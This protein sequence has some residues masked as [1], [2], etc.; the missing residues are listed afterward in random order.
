M[1]YSSDQFKP[2]EA[3]LIFRLNSFIQVK[4]KPVD[5][6]MLIVLGVN[7]I[8]SN[9]TYVCDHFEKR[10]AR[11]ENP[12]GFY[13]LKSWITKGQMLKHYPD[14]KTTFFPFESTAQFKNQLSE[15]KIDQVCIFFSD[16]DTNKYYKQEEIETL[17]RQYFLSSI[18]VIELKNRKVFIF[19]VV[20]K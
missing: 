7:F 17:K 5:I 3:W 2:N 8:N 16:I 4:E 9:F 1:Q 20:K 13:K 10:K 11:I 15:N 6:Y 18:K 19:E 14:R 12:E